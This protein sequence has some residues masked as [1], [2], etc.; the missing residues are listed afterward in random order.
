MK[1]NYVNIRSEA[2]RELPR[3]ALRVPGQHPP[4]PAV[5]GARAGASAGV[6]CHG[7]DEL[8]DRGHAP[9]AGE[10]PGEGG[11]TDHQRRGGAHD[12]PQT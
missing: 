1:Y 12:W 10:D 11:R 7:H 8:L 5:L 4:G 3:L 2:A 9:G 6:Q